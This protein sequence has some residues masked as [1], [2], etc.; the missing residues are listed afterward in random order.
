M[1]LQKCG[2]PWSQVWQV[3][4]AV[5]RW[6]WC[7]WPACKSSPPLRNSWSAEP[8]HLKTAQQLNYTNS[9]TPAHTWDTIVFSSKHDYFYHPSWW[10]KTDTNPNPISLLFKG[11]GSV[12]FLMKEKNCICMFFLLTLLSLSLWK[13]YIFFCLYIYIYIYI[14]INKTCIFWASYLNMNKKFNGFHSDNDNV[15]NF[16]FVHLFIMS[17]VCQKRK[18]INSKYIKIDKG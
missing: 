6:C 17:F 13:L 8:Q 5:C 18:C 14:Y 12:A 16:S 4:R 11:W 3:S 1:A 7:L 10:N 2:V 9:L 15:S